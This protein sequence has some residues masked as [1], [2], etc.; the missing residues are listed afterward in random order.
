MTPTAG[1][2]AYGSVLYRAGGE[3]LAVVGR[4]SEQPTLA[5]VLYRSPPYDL[6]VPALQMPRLSI[7]LTASSVVG[8]IE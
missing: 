5:V 6:Q 7:N 8:G 3:Q 4:P 1:I 2:T